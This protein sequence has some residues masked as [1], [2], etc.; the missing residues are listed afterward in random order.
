MPVAEMVQVPGPERVRVLVRGR[1]GGGRGRS[2]DRSGLGGG[3]GESAK[4]HCHPRDSF[5]VD[6]QS[7][8]HGIPLGL[9]DRGPV[10]GAGSKSIHDRPDVGSITDDFTGR[11]AR[12]EKRPEIGMDQGLARRNSLG[13]S[14]GEAIDRPVDDQTGPTGVV[15]RRGEFVRSGWKR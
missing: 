10:T 6:R 11:G 7:C 8:S 12:T 2:R 9:I 1:G 3:G 14:L 4:D 5:G 15:D 13:R